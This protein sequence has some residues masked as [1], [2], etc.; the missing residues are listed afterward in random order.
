MPSCLHWKAASSVYEAALVV[1][2]AAARRSIAVDPELEAPTGEEW[3]GLKTR[4]RTWKVTAGDDDVDGRSP[5]ACG[6]HNNSSGAVAMAVYRKWNPTW[7]SEE[8]G[9]PSSVVWW[10]K[11]WWAR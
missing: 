1:V 2:V 10:V 4:P 7:I 5:S 3:R 6:E 11:T 9:E 8:T